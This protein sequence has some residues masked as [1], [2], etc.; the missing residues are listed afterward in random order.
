MIP[1]IQPAPV[2][3]ETTNLQANLPP[4][5]PTPDLPQNIV[6]GG[7]DGNTI[8]FQ[9]NTATGGVKAPT[10]NTS[11]RPRRNNVGTYKDGPAIIQRL[12]ISGESYYFSF[13]N[14][15]IIEWEHPVPVVANQGRTTKYHP[16]QKSLT[17]ISGRMLSFARQLV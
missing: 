16:T 11:G 4:L 10:D 6:P 7:D 9:E 14:I 5:F 8:P 12:P 2:S 17:R 3:S 13:S 15:V 1:V